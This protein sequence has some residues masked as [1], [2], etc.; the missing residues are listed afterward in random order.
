MS[1][2]KDKIKKMAAKVNKVD[3]GNRDFK[4]RAD[5]LLGAGTYKGFKEYKKRH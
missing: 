2:A 1:K 4:E 5:R 3:H